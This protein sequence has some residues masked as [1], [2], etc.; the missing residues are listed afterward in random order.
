[1]L[2]EK[3]HLKSMLMEKALLKRKLT[4]EFILI[5]IYGWGYLT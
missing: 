1:M 5:Y 4:F 3:A 2:M